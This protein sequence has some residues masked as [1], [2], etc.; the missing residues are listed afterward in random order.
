MEFRASNINKWYQPHGI[1]FN[2]I[3]PSANITDQYLM[4]VISDDLC[5]SL[6]SDYAKESKVRPIYK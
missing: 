6:F 1:S 4:I 3:K 2:F 5:G